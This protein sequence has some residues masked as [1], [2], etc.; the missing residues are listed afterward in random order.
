MTADATPHSRPRPPGRKPAGGPF[1]GAPAA[2]AGEGPPGKGRWAETA[3]EGMADQLAAVSCGGGQ[4]DV[5]FASMPRPHH[6]TNQLQ[7]L[8]SNLILHHPPKAQPSRLPAS[9]SGRATS[10]PAS[11]SL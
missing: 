1:A 6:T 4:V 10:T 3:M 7:P 8:S 2:W 9:A 5:R 11:Y